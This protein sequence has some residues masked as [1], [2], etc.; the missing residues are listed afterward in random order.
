MKPLRNLNGVL[1]LNKPAGMTSNAAL[2]KV[3]HLFHA[4][5]A[6]H[7]GSL[8]PM[9][10]GMLPI[11]FGEAT[12]F[13][14]FFLA[15]D[16]AYVTKATLGIKTDT[17]DADGSVIEEAFV[18]DISSEQLEEVM[19]QFRGDILQIPP[20]YS[21]LKHKGQRLYDLARKGIVVEREPRPVHIHALSCAAFKPE[22]DVKQLTLNVVCSK[23]TYI[24]TLVEDIAE[25][26]GTVGHVEELHRT[27][28]GHFDPSRM[29]TLAQLE[30]EAEAG[31]ASL[32]DRHLV[33]ISD[34]LSP[35]PKVSLNES[36]VYY[37]QQGQVITAPDLPIEGWV[38]VCNPA[39]EL[40]GVGEINGSSRIA[41][42][43]LL[44]YETKQAVQ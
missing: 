10:M 3:K 15:E 43:K 21:A 12:K 13:A 39:G 5:K 44:K 30:K 42:R 22:Q 11:C 33:P 34:A 26:L 19:S 20:M 16:K 23:G 32:L 41:P 18:P 9:A 4:K 28:V 8:D 36:S 27:F 37:F 2:Q 24:R 14:Q 35:W 1:L 38:Q 7:T 6:G 25:A 31:E 40:I 17:G 29:V